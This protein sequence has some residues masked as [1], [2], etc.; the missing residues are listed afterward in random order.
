LKRQRALIGT[1]Q[2]AREVQHVIV[3]ALILVKTEENTV[4]QVMVT[5]DQWAR[6]QELFLKDGGLVVANDPVPFN[7]SR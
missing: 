2:P 7:W 1:L 4:L 6:I 3:D 5:P